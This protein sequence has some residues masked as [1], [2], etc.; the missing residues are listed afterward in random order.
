MRMENLK[1]PDNVDINLY[2]DDARRVIQNL[3]D[4]KYDAI[5]L[6]PFSQNMAPELVSLD[7]FNEFRRVIKE[8]GIVAFNSFIKLN[9]ETSLCY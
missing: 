7:F 4:D 6:D 2:I 8:N 5:F 1:I 3:E 9:F